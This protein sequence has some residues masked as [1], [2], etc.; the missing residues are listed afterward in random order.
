MTFSVT[1]INYKIILQEIEVNKTNL[2]KKLSSI[3]ELVNTLILQSNMFQNNG[4]A[5]T[6]KEK[7]SKATQILLLNAYKDSKKNF[8]NSI[9]LLKEEID[10]ITEQKN[11]F[12]DSLT[13]SDFDLLVE[14]I[15]SAY[16]QVI[17][18]ADERLKKLCNKMSA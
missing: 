15:E 13:E 2:E 9:Q 17:N 10:S 12:L 18:A 4:M 11:S 8:D 7:I 16:E 5:S 14:D 1:P 6:C 3:E